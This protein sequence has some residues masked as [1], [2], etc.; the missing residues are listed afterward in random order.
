MLSFK[1]I[2]V[3]TDFSENSVHALEFAHY[4]AKQS[5]S[6]LHVL[7]IIEPINRSKPFNDNFSELRFERSRFLE[8]E[9]ELRRFIN[10]ISLQGVQIIEALDPGK[11][12]EQILRYSRNHNI[13]LIVIASHGWTGLTNMTTGSIAN[14]ILRASEVPTILVKSN[15]LTMQNGIKNT[16]NSFAENWV[17]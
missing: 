9:E 5:K 13:D 12:N 17:G 15:S 6:A 8:A 3:P 4:L 16:K 7:H 10:R 1:N 14:K 11:P 2:L